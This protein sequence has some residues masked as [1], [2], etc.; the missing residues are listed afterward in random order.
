MA[1]ILSTT[2]E[3]K[4]Y[5]CISFFSLNNMEN[6]FEV[7]CFNYYIV[8][9][10]SQYDRLN[11]EGKHTPEFTI[12]FHK[13]NNENCYCLDCKQLGQYWRCVNENHDKLCFQKCTKCL[14]CKEASEI[15]NELQES[16]FFY[17]NTKLAGADKPYQPVKWHI[18]TATNKSKF[19]IE[20][21]KSIPHSGPW[22]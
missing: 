20:I 1:S 16:Y 21:A 17:P 18:F 22:F 6:R 8:R 3:E 15:Y 7:C 11:C 19:R 10:T 13:R 2:I 9:F 12:Y 5:F 4:K 14:I